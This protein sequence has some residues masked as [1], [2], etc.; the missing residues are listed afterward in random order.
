MSVMHQVF[1]GKITKNLAFFRGETKINWSRL[2]LLVPFKC[3]PQK[4]I[5]KLLWVLTSLFIS[6]L[7]CSKFWERNKTKNLDFFGG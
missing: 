5:L 1:W 6:Y 4:N 2:A 7:S 3:H